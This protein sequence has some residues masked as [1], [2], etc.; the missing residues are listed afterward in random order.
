MR[1]L[2]LFLS[3]AIFSYGSSITI[4][5]AANVSYAIPSLIKSFNQH[6]PNIKVNTTLGSSGKLTAQITYGAPYD[7]LLSANML[8]PNRLYKNNFAI[9]KPIVYAKGSLVLFSIKQRDFIKGIELLKD[10]SIKTI[11]IPNPKTAP[12]GV[13]AKEALEN[14]DLYKKIKPKF[15]YGESV[16]QTVIYTLKVASIGI[17]AKSVLF[18]PR[19]SNYKK[20]INWIDIDQKL[21]TPI[22][23]GIVIL[24]RAKNNQDVKAFYD[25]ILSKEGKKILNNFGYL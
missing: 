23:Q 22:D 7:M 13:A 1:K 9:T 10:N 14:I 4:A 15:I 11:A 20:E 17:V 8:Y 3:I 24:K 18:S 12:Y 21:Y 2:F 16:S 25:F 19:M 6:Y 5:V